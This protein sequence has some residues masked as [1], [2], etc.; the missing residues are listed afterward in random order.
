[1]TFRGRSKDLT[2]SLTCTDPLRRAAAGLI[3]AFAF[4]RYR[5][6][7]KRFR[8]VVVLM[9]A[10]DCYYAAGAAHDRLDGHHAVAAALAQASRQ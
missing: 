6:L 7:Q 10:D 5:S 9:R 2:P 3:R 4:S 1:M 8:H